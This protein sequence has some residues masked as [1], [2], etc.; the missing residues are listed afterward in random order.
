MSARIEVFP[1]VRKGWTV[2]DPDEIAAWYWRLVGANGEKVCVSEAYTRKSS[3]KR[4]AWRAIVIMS[5]LRFD[6]TRH[7]HWP[8]HFPAVIV[9]VAS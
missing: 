3:A 5:E 7:K 1:Q 8:S 9:E 2:D 6:V 4:G